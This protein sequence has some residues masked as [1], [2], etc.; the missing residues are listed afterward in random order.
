[1]D[2]LTIGVAAGV[3]VLVAAGLATASVLRAHSAPPD[4]TTPHGVVLAYAAAEDRADGVAAWNLLAMATQTRTD[5]DE[6]LARVGRSMPRGTGEY[7][8]TEDEQITGNE[9]SVVLVRA[10]PG[11]GSIFGSQANAS[12]AT[13]RMIHEPDGWRITVPPD[14]Y[15]LV[16]TRKGG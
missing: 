6:Y 12:R 3:L 4:L 15:N 11:S 14:E 8:T 16:Q 7:V 10:Y 13:V 9:A 5:R 2:K 1:M